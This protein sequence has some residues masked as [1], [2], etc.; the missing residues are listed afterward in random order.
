MN[1]TASIIVTGT[2]T[3]GKVAVEI[4]DVDPRSFTTIRESRLNVPWPG[5]PIK[6]GKAAIEKAVYGHIRALRALGRDTVNTVE[7]AQAL[8]ISVK[9][10][11]ASIANLRA[12]GVKPAR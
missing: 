4:R 3:S 6:G 7:I 2:S 1:D 8:G 10:V 12:K 11:D 5:E 9:E